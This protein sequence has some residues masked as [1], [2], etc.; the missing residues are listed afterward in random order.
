MIANRWHGYRL[1]RWGT[2]SAP[3]SL[4]PGAILVSGC[5]QPP[6]RNPRQSIRVMYYGGNVSLAERLVREY[7][8]SM[9]DID[10]R[11]LRDHPGT[12][13]SVSVIEAL[14]RGDTDLGFALADAT[15][16]AHRSEH[17]K[18]SNHMRG[19]SLLQVTSLHVLVRRGL[20]IKRITELSGRKVR[21]G[22]PTSAASPND[23]QLISELT[24]KAFGVDTRSIQLQQ[25]TFGPA[26]ERLNAGQLDAAFVNASYPMPNV[27]TAIRA[28]ARLL[29]IEGPTVER[30]RRSIRLFGS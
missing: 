24:L 16:F 6:E 3:I 13:L 10:V 21:L 5:R 22:A 27:S 19:I 30:L 4:F 29:P 1:S 25:L 23:T 14:E 8:Q 20:D 7:S 11:L 26:V 18:I 15:Y 17:S 2:A 9:P 12:G 28:G